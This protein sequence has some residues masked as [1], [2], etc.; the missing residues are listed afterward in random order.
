MAEVADQDGVGESPGEL[1]EH[2]LEQGEQRLNRSPLAAAATGFVG[3]FDVMIGVAIANVLAGRLA[4]VMPD[5]LAT[6]LGASVFGIGFVL[7][8]LGRSELF[9]E[10]FLIPVGAVLEGRRPARQLPVLW[11][12]TLGSNLLG[13]FVLALILSESTVL[14][15]SAVFA[16]GRT[17]TLLAE[18]TPEAAF[19]SGVVAGL[20]MTLW[21]WLGLAIRTDVARVIVAMAIGFTI[22]AP[23]MNHVIVGSGEMMFGLLGGHTRATWGDAGANFLLALAG[24][25]IGGTLFVTL[26]RFLQVRTDS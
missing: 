24:N 5:K 20:V 26:T 14:N 6:T 12:A 7:I 15:R 3:G 4:I 11:L 17:A 25:L 8:T 21:T 1:W 23:T 10:N 9:T 2:G 16:V 13:M 18:R 19:L 22:A